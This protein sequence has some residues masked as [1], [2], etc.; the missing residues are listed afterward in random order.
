[1]P[2]GGPRNGL[3]PLLGDR[4]AGHPAQAVGA[5]VEPFER[6]VDLV[7][8]GAGLSAEREVEVALDR[9]RVAFAGLF[10]ELHVAGFALGHEGVGFVF[11]ELCVVHVLRAFFEQQL[12]LLVEELLV[13]RRFVVGGVARLLSLHGL[14]GDLLVV[15]GFG[16][17]CLGGLRR[18]SFGGGLGCLGGR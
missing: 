6:G 2:F 16:R 1:D 12:A 9:K 13:E 3:Q 10:V 15:G 5:V 18:R 4:L 14:G 11:V 17:R 8:L 7:D